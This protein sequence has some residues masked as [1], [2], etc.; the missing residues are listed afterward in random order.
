MRT[1]FHCAENCIH[2]MVHFSNVYNRFFSVIECLLV[3]ECGLYASSRYNRITWRSNKFF[4]TG[5]FCIASICSDVNTEDITLLTK[6]AFSIKPGVTHIEAATPKIVVTERDP[7]VMHSRRLNRIISSV[8]E[9]S[10]YSQLEHRSPGNHGPI[11][12]T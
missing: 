1:S 2:I 6:S 4:Q 11:W 7:M 12:P 5:F 8:D 9:S 3:R 10:S